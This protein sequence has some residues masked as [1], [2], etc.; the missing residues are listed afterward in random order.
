[1]SA[2]LCSS[3]I[4]KSAEIADFTVKLAQESPRSIMLFIFMIKPRCRKSGFI[5]NNQK[6]NHSTLPPPPP[7][8]TAGPVQTIVFSLPK[9][10]RMAWGCLRAGH[11]GLKDVVLI[12]LF[13]SLPLRSKPAFSF[14]ILKTDF[15]GDTL[16]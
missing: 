6:M 12:Y 15:L 2:L 3:R 9:R 11:R 14:A 13:I 1:M 8:P 10:E 16:V 5:L 7:S 4:R